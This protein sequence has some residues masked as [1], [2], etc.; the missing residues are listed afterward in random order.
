MELKW[1]FVF[2]GVLIGGLIVAA[3]VGD[4]QRSNC[5]ETAI[6]AHMPVDDIAKICK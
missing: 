6:Q 2:M 4:Y 3:S 1:F 5:R